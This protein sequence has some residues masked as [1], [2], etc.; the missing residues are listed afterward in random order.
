MRGGRGGGP[1]G[2]E[3]GGGEMMGTGDRALGRKGEWVGGKVEQEGERRGLLGLG[4]GHWEGGRGN[5]KDVHAVELCVCVYMYVCM[6]MCKC[7]C[8]CMSVL[9]V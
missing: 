7:M 6:R 5:M 2:R 3:I 9:R 1:L 4:T 8:V